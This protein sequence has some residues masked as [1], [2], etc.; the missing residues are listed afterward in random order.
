MRV[1][2]SHVTPVMVAVVA[3]LAAAVVLG[4]CAGIPTAGE[5]KARAGLA[6]AGRAY[7]PDG[8]KPALP[9]LDAT[10]TLATLMAYAMLNDPRVEAAYYDYAAA[11]ERITTE[12]S[13]P[14]PRLGLELDIQDIVMV[15][16]PGLMTELPWLGR[17]GLRAGVAT[18]ESEAKY[19]AFEAAVLD[20]AF[21]VRRPCYRLHFLGERI[22]ILRET[23]AL[24]TELERIA[25]AQS[26]A[27]KVTLQDVLRAQIEQERLV[28]EVA[29]LEDSRNPLV[30]QIKAALGL[31][32]D[33][34]DPP[35]PARFEPAPEMSAEQLL[36]TALVRNPRLKAME[37]EVRMAEAGIRLAHQTRAPDF[38]VGVEADAKAAPV[39]WRPTVGFTVPLWRDKIAAEIAGAQARKEAAEARLSAEQVQ[40]AVEFA[41]KS[42]MYR[43]ATRN[44]KL[45]ADSLLPKARMSLD[46]AREAYS[47]GRL[48]FINLLDAER[49]LLEFQIAEVDARTQREAALAELSLVI[50]GNQPPGSP[51]AGRDA[52][53]TST[54]PQGK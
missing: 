25:R 41:D 33:Q 6:S 7:R 43:E 50:A 12:R 23:L 31:R 21:R 54:P 16:M 15:I 32:A 13:L 53:A 8:H 4:G 11:V 36:A 44:L 47:A 42:F 9:K 2:K 22:R 39:L 29:N 38:N 30:A 1:R 27:G 24:M 17:L 46:I 28:T 51:A 20:A 5:R 26:E 52:T 35:V 18:A 37:E 3:A 10:A 19:H 40:L 34:P 48:D 45:L 14:D 49:T